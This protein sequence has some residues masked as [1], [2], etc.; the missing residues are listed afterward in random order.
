ML[1]KDLPHLL[2][3]VTDGLL[4]DLGSGA[5]KAAAFV[6]TCAPTPAPL[7]SIEGFALMSLHLGMWR[8]A[9]FSLNLRPQCGQGTRE[10]S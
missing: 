6:R 8:S 9:A 2:R 10:G 5:V 3:A 7:L 4:A 1:Q